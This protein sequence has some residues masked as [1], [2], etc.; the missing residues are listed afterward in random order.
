VRL[1]LHAALV[2]LAVIACTCTLHLHSVRP[3]PPLAVPRAGPACRSL[4]A[5]VSQGCPDL[6]LL[7]V[8]RCRGVAA[9]LAELLYAAK[10][11]FLVPSRPPVATHA[12][13][14]APP[15]TRP[16]C[17]AALPTGRRFQF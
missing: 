10:T 8:P 4:P 6:L 14:A 11:S 12:H 9:P 13:T 16:R 3:C 7:H 2:E 5:A 1:H 17:A 15:C